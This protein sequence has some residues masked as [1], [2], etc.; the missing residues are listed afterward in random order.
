VPIAA[1]QLNAQ[2][3]REAALNNVS[4]LTVADVAKRYGVDVRTVLAWGR[5]GDLILLNVGRSKAKKR[6]TWRV[7]SEALA[8]FELI[9]THQQAAPRT[10]R[11]RTKNDESVINFY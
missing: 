11:R 8:R 4:A 1:E 10:R 3:R 6:A 9:R 5:S 7:T 2:R